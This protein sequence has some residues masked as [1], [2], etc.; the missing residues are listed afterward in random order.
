MISYPFI[1]DLFKN[2]L[3]KS[4]GIEGRFYIASKGG[5]EINSDLLQQVLT[6]DVLVK[7]YPLSLLM[8]P[9]SQGNYTDRAGE[10]E[11]YHFTMF[12]LKT[13]YYDS[14]NQISN[15]N[16]NT[17]TSMHTIAQDW[18]DMK[19]CAVN[20]IRVLDKVQ[21]SLG[22]ITTSFRL[23]ADSKAITPVSLVGIDR[24]SGVRLDFNASLFIG[25]DIGE[26]YTDSDISSITLPE[27]DSH[28]EHKM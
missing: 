17:Q 16:P 11:K 4:K 13:T 14:N 1:Q 9:R 24:V 15:I 19:R 21:K 18:H 3:S 27:G 6:D 12:F 26:D 10:W 7:K 2:I 25:C 22:L 23:P 20:F 8:P 5:N 28:P